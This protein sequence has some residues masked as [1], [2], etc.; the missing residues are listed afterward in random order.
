MSKTALQK[1]ARLSF[2][3]MPAGAELR[4]DDELG[5]IVERR[6]LKKWLVRFEVRDSP[7]SMRWRDPREVLRAVVMRWPAHGPE[8]AAAAEFNVSMGNHTVWFDAL[9]PA[10][11]AARDMLVTTDVVKRLRGD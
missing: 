1:A 4:L 10:L 7:G 11:Y 6:S 5:I 8:H 9:M 2:S 3:A